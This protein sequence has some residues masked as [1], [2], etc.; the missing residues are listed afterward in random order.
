MP[1]VLASVPGRCGRP[2]SE[3]PGVVLV[4]GAVALVVEAVI[5]FLHATFRRMGG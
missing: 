3:L 1:G 2:A 5:R 4:I